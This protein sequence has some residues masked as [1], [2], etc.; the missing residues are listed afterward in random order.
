MP[1]LE[2]VRLD[3]TTVEEL[4]YLAQRLDALPDEDLLV[5]RALFQKR[6]REA[7]SDNLPSVKDLINMT[8]GLGSVMVASNVTNDE[9]L[10]Q[11]V[12]ENDL[13]PDVAAIP[14]ESLYLL[15]KRAVGELQRQVDGGVYMDGVY[16]VTGVYELPDIYDGEHLPEP[17]DEYADVPDFGLQNEVAERYLTMSDAEHVKFKAILEAEDIQGMDEVLKAADRL[18]EYELAYLD[19]DAGTFYRDY[20]SHHL[21]ADFDRRWLDTLLTENEGQ[22]L[23]DRLGARLTEYGVLS[24]RGGHLYEPVPYDAPETGQTTEDPL[25]EEDET[26]QQM[27]GMQL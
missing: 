26:A 8:Y 25:L 11:F 23:L 14:E 21:S 1:E 9:Q 15:D 22:R 20:L 4:N 24:A 17:E 13:H 12:I 2:D 6:Y 16:V 7:G 19:G 10:G 18:E 3:T 5:Y 27:G